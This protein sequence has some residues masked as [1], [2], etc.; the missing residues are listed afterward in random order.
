LR[1]SASAAPLWLSRAVM[2][3]LTRAISAS[4]AAICLHVLAAHPVERQ[5]LEAWPLPGN[6]LV[7]A[8][9]PTLDPHDADAHIGA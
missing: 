1:N 2:V 3:A 5:G 7:L 4:S 8:Q 6:I 9:H